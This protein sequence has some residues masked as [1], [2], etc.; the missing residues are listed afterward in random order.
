MESGWGVTPLGFDE[1]PEERHQVQLIG[2]RLHASGSLCVRARLRLSDYVN[3][4]EGFFRIEDVVLRDRLGRPT[5]VVLPE[6]RIRLD[7]ITIV[8]QQR[9]KVT[10]ELVDSAATH[11]EKSPRRL[12]VMTTAHEIYGYVH[13][14]DAATFVAYVDAE[15]PRFIPMSNVHVRW[16]EDRRLAGR[17]DFALLRRCHIIGVATETASNL[18]PGLDPGA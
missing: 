12:V 5:R 13:L 7:D 18:G 10:H 2:T 11:V 6:V 9:P 17:F 4:L 3:N 1:P 16:L 15:Y 14:Q 8:G